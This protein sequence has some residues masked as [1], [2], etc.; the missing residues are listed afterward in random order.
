MYWLGSFCNREGPHERIWQSW[1]SCDEVSR[2]TRG[3]TY[4]QHGKLNTLLPRLGSYVLDEYALYLTVVLNLPREALIVSPLL[5]PTIP[6]MLLDA[7]FSWNGSF[8]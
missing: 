5:S 7:Y 4:A 2:C 3:T 8:T 1:C 6:G